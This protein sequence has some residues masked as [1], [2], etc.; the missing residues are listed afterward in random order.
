[1]AVVGPAGQNPSGRRAIAAGGRWAGIS[2]RPPALTGAVCLCICSRK[3]GGSGTHREG[4]GRGRVSGAAAGGVEG[5]GGG[6]LLD[7]ASCLGAPRR[8]GSDVSGRAGRAV[9]PPPLPALC[10]RGEV[11]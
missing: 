10:R 5:G 1:M 3:P 7:A 9:L 4:H 8:V 11:R 2:G 6:S